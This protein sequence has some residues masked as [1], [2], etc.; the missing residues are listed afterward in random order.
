MRLLVERQLQQLEIKV[1][2]KFCFEARLEAAYECRKL[3]T[4]NYKSI[5][6]F[7]VGQCVIV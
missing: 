5:K 7:P 1:F 2:L 3:K 4:K 6:F